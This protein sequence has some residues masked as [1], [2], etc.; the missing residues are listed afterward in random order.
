MKASYYCS[1]TAFKPLIGVFSALMNVSLFFVTV[2]VLLNQICAEGQMCRSW[3]MSIAVTTGCVWGGFWWNR[4]EQV[5]TTLQSNNHLQITFQSLIRRH[6]ARV[7]G[8]PVLFIGLLWNTCSLR[9]PQNDSL[10]AISSL[11]SYIFLYP[12]INFHS[13]LAIQTMLLNI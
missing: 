6:T 11:P 10:V 12:W 9:T 13:L 1:V 8:V 4:N 7:R 3:K 2:L 5:K